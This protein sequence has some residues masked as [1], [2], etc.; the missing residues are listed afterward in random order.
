MKQIKFDKDADKVNVT[1]NDENYGYLVFDKDQ[2]AWVLWP[3]AIDDG[4]TYWQSLKDTENQIKEEL[5]S[6]NN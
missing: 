4:V 6:S 2:D 5:Q 1:V 3:K